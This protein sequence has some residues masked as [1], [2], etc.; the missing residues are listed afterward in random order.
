MEDGLLVPTDAALD[1]DVEYQIVR[2]LFVGLTKI[3]I[4]AHLKAVRCIW[5]SLVTA[6]GT[7][8]ETIVSKIT[9]KGPEFKI[10]D[11]D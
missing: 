11:W 10:D 4:Q 6:G 1:V 7:D 8:Y 5:K 3:E 9:L 2:K